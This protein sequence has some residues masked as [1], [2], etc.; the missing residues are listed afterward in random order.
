MNIRIGAVLALFITSPLEAKSCYTE[1]AQDAWLSLP[2]HAQV[3]ERRVANDKE[4][5]APTSDALLVLRVNPAEFSKWAKDC[6]FVF[7][8]EEGLPSFNWT[9][10]TFMGLITYDEKKHILRVE[11]HRHDEI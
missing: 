2:S 7:S 3:L 1:N 10:E 8:T 5:A 4:G 9:S 11:A 6:R